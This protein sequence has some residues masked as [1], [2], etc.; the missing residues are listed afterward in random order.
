MFL[1][2]PKGEALRWLPSALG[3]RTRLA[4]PRRLNIGRSAALRGSDTF[5]PRA[6][7][8]HQ[9]QTRSPQT[10]L[11]PLAWT[12]EGEAPP[13]D[14]VGISATHPHDDLDAHVVKMLSSQRIWLAVGC[15]LGLGLFA[16]LWSRAPALPAFRPPTP[17]QHFHQPQ[18]GDA[19]ASNA[20]AGSFL[21]PACTQ[22]DGLGDIAFVL[23]TGATEIYEK[24]PIHFRTTFA[25][26]ADY[27]IYS[28]LG[29]HFGTVPV[30]DALALVSQD[31]RDSHEDLA[32][33]RL[34]KEHVAL[35]G[36]ASELKGKKSWGL[37]KYKFLPMVTDAY[38]TFG[39]SK[40]WY[41]FLEADTYVSHQNLLL[42]LATLD[43][44]KPVYAGAQVMIGD[45][46]FAH[47]GSGFVLSAVAAKA[48]VATYEK[49]QADWERKLASECCGDKLVADVLFEA[50]PSIKLL[51]SFPLIQ[52]E[53]LDSLDWSQTH[54]CKPA[55]TW[56]HVDAGAIDKLWQFDREWRNDR[57]TGEPLLFADYFEAFIHPRLAVANGTIRGWDNLAKDWS[58]R[59]GEVESPT[60]E[61]PDACAHFCQKQK[62]CLQWSWS[63][64]W[65]K[66]GRVVRLGWALENRPALGSADDRIAHLEADDEEKAVSGWLLER[67]Q[68]YVD[69]Q[70]ECDRSPWR[71][72]TD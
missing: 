37:D 57:G 54:W 52:G 12:L 32:Q 6:I 46:E 50:S 2:R 24:L 28:D 11:R 38:K 22:L 29:Q 59:E 25:C 58:F 33:Y 1:R 30:R 40:A 4:R 18:Q 66:A 62:Q 36:D 49:Q 27:L 60:Y 10:L 34:Q 48:F 7:S 8:Q 13:V 17:H 71:I 9:S 42:W 63:P 5:G 53:T 35:G 39:D 41:V 23:K 43:A 72:Y 14:R 21:D 68:R 47:G 31:L 69:K 15:L 44:S 16:H 26:T 45:T 67:V 19:G 3:N 55:V 64:G 51:T 70:G 61:S 65:C 20:S 56:H